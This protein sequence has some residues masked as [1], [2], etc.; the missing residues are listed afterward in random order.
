MWLINVYRRWRQQRPASIGPHH[1]I[2]PTVEFHH[3]ENITVGDYVFIGP[4]SFLDGKGGIEI[5]DGAVLGPRVVILSSSHQYRNDELLPFHVF[6][7]HRKVT[8]GRGVWIGFGAMIVP[9]VVV[10]DG[11]VIGM[12]AVVTRPV[13]KGSVVG[14]NPARKIGSRPP[15][16]VDRLIHE[17]AY[18]RK[19]YWGQKPK[20]PGVLPATR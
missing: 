1:V 5:G 10:G 11:A 8:I 18:F 19:R 6:D 9:G 15:G 17:G 16:L 3:S 12:G 4:G 7:E 2:H 13:A 20:R 14:G